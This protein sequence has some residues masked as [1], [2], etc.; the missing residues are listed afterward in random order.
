MITHPGA[1]EL[2][3]DGCAEAAGA[4]AN[5]EYALAGADAAALVNLV[6]GPLVELGPHG[7]RL[8]VRAQLGLE[9]RVE[10]GE[11]QSGQQSHCGSQFE[12]FANWGSNE[13]DCHS[14]FETQF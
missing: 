4:G 2:R 12:F 5:D 7:L 13:E 8:P 3:L 9:P 11:L 14:P 1:Q 6:A 10:G